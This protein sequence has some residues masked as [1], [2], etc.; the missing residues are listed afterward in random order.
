MGAEDKRIQPGGSFIKGEVRPTRRHAGRRV[1]F[2]LTRA[3][4][5]AF[6]LAL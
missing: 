2:L 3:S 6:R 4:L 1:F 5:Q